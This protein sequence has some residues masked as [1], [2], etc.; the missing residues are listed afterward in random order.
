MRGFWSPC[1]ELHLA[2][3]RACRMWELDSDKCVCPLSPR[4]VVKFMHV[5]LKCCRGL[6]TVQLDDIKVA[7][8][9]FADDVVILTLSDRHLRCEPEWSMAWVCTYSETVVLPR[10]K[11]FKCLLFRLIWLL[12]MCHCVPLH[13]LQCFICLLKPLGILLHSCLVSF[14]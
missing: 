5:M 6:E 2:L 7:S 11:T 13:S 1:C 8:L 4:T 14:F 12:L 3:S 9:L 10:R